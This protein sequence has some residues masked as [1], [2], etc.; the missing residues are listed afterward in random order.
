M[1]KESKSKQSAQH[2]HFMALTL[3]IAEENKRQGGYGVG[4]MVVKS[5]EIIASSDNSIRRTCDPTGHAEVNAIREAS[6]RLNS[7]RLTDCWLYSSYEPC[8]MCAAAA[9]WAR[10]KGIVFANRIYDSRNPQSY[11]VDVTCE[12]IVNASSPK[13]EIIPDVLRERG[14]ALM[15]FRPGER[16]K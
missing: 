12:A 3:S 15:D 6:Q 11:R 9:A 5:G 16:K 8:A 13:L 1:S 10:M 7:E 2:E 4:A 14:M